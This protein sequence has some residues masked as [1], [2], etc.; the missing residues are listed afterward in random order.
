MKLLTIFVLL[1]GC[2]VYLSCEQNGAMLNANGA[3][4]SQPMD[5]FKN[6]L[7]TIYDFEIDYPATYAMKDKQVALFF[8]DSE[9]VLLWNYDGEGNS[10]IVQKGLIDEGKTFSD[11]AD[12]KLNGK[13]TIYIKYQGDLE[14]TFNLA[15]H[16]GYHFYGQDWLNDVE[17]SG[18]KPRGSFYP[19]DEIYGHLLRES[20]LRLY[21][22]LKGNNNFG[23][24]EALYFHNV[25]KKERPGALELDL[26]TN[27]LEGTANFVE[28]LFL[29][30]AKEP[31]LQSDYR[32]LSRLA[33]ELNFKDYTKDIIYDKGFEYY[34]IS[35]LPY[36]YLSIEGKGQYLKSIIEDKYP[37]ELLKYITEPKQARFDENT[38]NEVMAYFSRINSK[39]KTIIE[40]MIEKSKSKAFITIQIQ[41]EF[42]EGSVEFGEFINFKRGEEYFTINTETAVLSPSIHLKYIDTLTIYISGIPYYEVY[43]PEQNVTVAN[44]KLSVNHEQITITAMPFTRI[45]GGY[46]VHK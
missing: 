7:D 12:G 40:D 27:L 43:I 24:A 17:I 34:K 38:K 4:Y 2:P 44:G 33:F 5:G 32:G 21:G 41:E 15:V 11:F 46:R 13:D 14:A 22:K 8:D 42:F 39:N 3:G 20:F 1:L 6:M 37:Y 10:K 30:A 29:A 45:D 9:S 19:E 36:Y 31:K 35:S 26:F 18:I 23:D 28:S 25:L 16:E